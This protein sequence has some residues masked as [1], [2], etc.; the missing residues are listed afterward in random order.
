MGNFYLTECDLSYFDSAASEWRVVDNATAHIGESSADIRQSLLLSLPKST[1]STETTT[2]VMT[3]T[4]TTTTATT[5]FPMTTRASGALRCR[6]QLV[7]YLVVLL[8][9]CRR[10]L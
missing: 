6:C 3:T 5:E 4:P 2:Q 9:M 8:H 7:V 10:T 1:L